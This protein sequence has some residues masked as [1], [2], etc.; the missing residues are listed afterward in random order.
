MTVRTSEDVYKFVKDCI[1]IKEEIECTEKRKEKGKNANHLTSSHLPGSHLPGSHLPGNHLPG[2]HLPGRHLPCRY[3]P[4]DDLQKYN[5]DYSKFE[6]CIKEIE[7]EEEEEKNMEENKKSFLN[8]RNPCT[9]DHS[10]ERQ[11]YEKSSKEKIKASNA[12]NEEGKKLFYEKNYKLACVYFRKGLIQLDYSFP[13]TEQEKKEQNKLEI[14]LHL[15]LALTKF[16]MSN[17]YECISECSTVLSL[18]RNNV[19]AYYRKGQAYMSLDLYDEAREEFRKV[20]EIDPSDINTKQSLLTLRNK[21]LI[22]NKKKKL[23]CSK[24][25][26]FNEYKEQREKKEPDR[27]TNYDADD[28][29][30]ENMCSN[31][32]PYMDTTIVKKEDYTVRNMHKEKI[33]INTLSNMIT[34]NNTYTDKQEEYIFMINSSKL[35]EKISQ[36]FLMNKIF[37]YLFIYKGPINVYFEKQSKLYCLVHTANNILQ[38]HL[39][40]PD[41]FKK[42][43]SNLDYSTLEK[44]KLVHNNDAGDGQSSEELMDVREKDKLSYENIFSYIKR[45]IYYFGNFNINIL[46][47]FMNKYNMELNWV[48]NKEI[49]QKI[50]M[51]KCTTLFDDKYLNNKKLI[52]FVI[53]VVKIKFF[54][55]YHH[56]HFYALRKISGI[57]IFFYTFL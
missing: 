36:F 11:L 33:K 41:D 9:H 53:N 27:S 55:I 29:I 7:D 57:N 6:R 18:D 23:V 48:D 30:K 40:S 31:P 20:L 46:Y 13:D 56:R 3:L 17:Y 42:Y 54:D 26:S 14:N 47:F 21:I 52:A 24:F 34:H 38:A 43:E 19:K 32:E 10:K 37:L 25:F 28:K 12:F 50:N 8:G 39:F 49:F 15:N 44:Q 5:L 1:K 4:S 51:E 16:Y 22:Y 2:N 35:F 45:G